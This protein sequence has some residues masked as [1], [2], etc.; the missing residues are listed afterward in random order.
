[1]LRK[2]R[3]GFYIILHF[4]VRIATGINALAMT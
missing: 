4:K 2:S 1:L 3:L